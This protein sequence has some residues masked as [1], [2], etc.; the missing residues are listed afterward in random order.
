MGL[1][2]LNDAPLDDLTDAS[3]DEP[4]RKRRGCLFYGCLSVV[5]VL[6]LLALLAWYLVTRS[7]TA[8][9]D[10]SPRPLPVVTLPPEQAEALQERASAFEEAVKAP[11]P[12][13]EEP[14]SLVLS[15]EEVNTLLFRENPG[16]QGKL[17][18]RLGADRLIAELSLPLDFLH[19][20]LFK[21]RYLN[22]RA[23]MN[24]SVRDGKVFAFIDDL[25]VNGRPL[26]KVLDRALKE[27]NLGEDLHFQPETQR[28]M[29]R[30]KSLEVK[31]HHLIIRARPRI[32]EGP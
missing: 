21:G 2:I 9:T 19:L 14:P 7:V 6:V 23:V 18:V 29:D 26:P 1:D 31:D 22:G 25:Q 10:E 27:K 5:L 15:E 20:R 11:E 8:Y 4:P 28:Y 13:V 32:A 24:V 30:I 3:P 12:E 16:L 17:L